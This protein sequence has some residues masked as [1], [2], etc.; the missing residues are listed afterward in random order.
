MQASASE[1]P[2]RGNYFAE[3]DYLRQNLPSGTLENRAGARMF[4]LP[5]E[6][7]VALSNTV[8]KHRGERCGEVL[9]SIGRGWGKQAAEQLSNELSGFHER[10]LDEQPLSLFAADLTA[11]FLHH[12]WGRLQLDFSRYAR[13]LLLVEVFHPFLGEEVK[14]TSHSV[15]ALMAGFLSGMFTQFAGV[16]LDCVQTACRARGEQ[17]SRFV[18]T[19]PQRLQA[20]KE[21]I[22]SGRA[23][24]EIVAAL[25]K[26]PA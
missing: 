9:K 25:E 6:L 18:L 23:H 15:E 14:P 26:R 2:L 5:D 7:L 12:G 3:A 1:L 24:D 10:R 8:M 4:A 21:L 11:A 17:S 16:E 13:G 22:E 19:V 20:I